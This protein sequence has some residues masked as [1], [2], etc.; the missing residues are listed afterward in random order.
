[1]DRFHFPSRLMIMPALVLTLILL[2]TGGCTDQTALL[3][4]DTTQG[5]LSAKAHTDTFTLLAYDVGSVHL[6]GSLNGW[7]D[8]DPGWELTLQPDG[9][10]WRLITQVPDGLFEY[11]Y[12]L[13][14]GALKEWL[15]DPAAV[16]VVPD[17]FHSSPAYWNSLRGREVV[18]PSPLPSPIDRSKLVI[19]E[20]SLN[21]FSASG[22]FAGAT[23]NLTTAA[24]L[25]D[26]GVNAIELMPVTAPSYNGWGYDPVLQYSTNPSFGSPANFA[27]LVDAAHS[28]GMAVILDSV[29]N[30]MSGSAPLRQLDNFTGTNHFTTLESNPWGLV[31]L[32]W[33]DPALKEHIL[34]SLCHWVDTYNVDGFRFDYIGG[35]PYST[36]IWIKDQLNAKYPDILLIGEDFNYP[37]NSITFG[38]DSQWGGNHTDQWGGGGNN[39]N[40]VM[41]TA[42]TQNGFAWR[43]SYVPSVG[44]WGIP[45]NNMW[46]V[47]NVIS[48]NS[49]YAGAAPGDGFS[50]VKF[51]ESHDE[52]RVVW[53][54]DNNGSI[55]AQGIG[56]LRKAHLG[57]VVSMTTIGIPML[58]NGQEIGSAEYRPEGT[59]TYKIN[60]NGGDAGVRLTYKRMIEF[61]LNLPALSSEN[62][63]FNW[64]D[65]NIDQVEYTMVYWRGSTPNGSQAEVVVACNFDHLDHTWNVAFP[66]T[67]TW[68]KFDAASG[69]METVSIPSLAQNITVPA[70]TALMW[71]REDGVTGVP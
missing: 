13:R 68:V 49:N 34:G 55:G 2:A 19:Y 9:Y 36:W 23:A 18:T 54:V 42:L 30:H 52:N 4:P 25:A 39:F 8:D 43:G 44:V 26:L 48:G 31:E 27:T 22:T 69:N 38:Y 63:F 47:A 45:Y 14:I 11:K 5:D 41:I 67:G 21:D 16:E 70:S 7:I 1:M 53:S 17:G 28:H 62:I 15:T 56:G 51:L 35:E 6:A 60:W 12:V 20:I 46:A 61:R 65:G 64:R 37:A 40:Q 71:V 57:A 58:Y 3:E 10:T 33:T 29:V 66:S 59:S 32:N 50:D 24:D